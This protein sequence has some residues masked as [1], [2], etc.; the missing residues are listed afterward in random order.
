MH[1]LMA[2]VVLID[3][4][5]PRAE[6]TYLFPGW[7]ISLMS[8]G[9]VVSTYSRAMGLILFL[10]HVSKVLLYFTICRQCDLDF[11]L[12]TMSLFDLARFCLLNAC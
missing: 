5:L 1:G 8:L 9:Y 12:T 2:K 7:S 3:I 4:Q 6:L 10:K 11:F